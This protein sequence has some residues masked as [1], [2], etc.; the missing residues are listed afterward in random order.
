MIR[1]NDV[2]D[3]ADKGLQREEN[4]IIGSNDRS[5][6]IEEVF[7]DT[8]DDVILDFIEGAVIEGT[9]EF[10]E[11]IIF[12][13]GITLWEN[14]FELRRLFLD[15]FHGMI[16]RLAN[17]SVVGEIQKIL[18]PCLFGKIDSTLSF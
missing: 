17:L 8:T 13:A 11:Q 6:L 18:I 16:D 10:T 9:E 4:A 2:Y 12:Q 15:E 1:F 3:H 7:I 5:K 14:T